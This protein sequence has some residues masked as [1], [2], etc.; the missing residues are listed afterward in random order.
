[1]DLSKA[2]DLYA[3][4]KEWKLKGFEAFIKIF[5]EVV[6]NPEISDKCFSRRWNLTS[7]LS[8]FSKDDKNYLMKFVMSIPN[9]KSGG[10]VMSAVRCDID[11]STYDYIAVNYVISGGA[12]WYI[13]Q[14]KF[15]RIK[16]ERAHMRM[17]ELEVEKS[18]IL[19]QLDELK[20]NKRN[21]DSDESE[22]EELEHVQKKVAANTD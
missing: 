20:S 14:S 19:K 18:Q 5:G 7:S 17:K 3:E 12:S 22:I 9:F 6:W 21:F 4:S 10:I 8:K 1:M 13:L 2:I 11:E 15:E 16:K